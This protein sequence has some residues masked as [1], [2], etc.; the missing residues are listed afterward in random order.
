VEGEERVGGLDGATLVAFVATVDPDRSHAF[1]SRVLGLEHV[2]STPFANVYR[3]GPAT[4][5]VTRVASLAPQGHTVVGWD[6]PDVYESVEV[7]RARGVAFLR[8]GGMEQDEN[9]VWSAPGGARIAWFQ[10]PDGNVLSVG[11]RTL[12]AGQDADQGP[13]V[14]VGPAAIVPGSALDEPP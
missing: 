12:P 13:G 9:G 14:S 7:L 5:R 1:Y 4:L 3:V 2:E 10:D 8:Y 6:V 11:E